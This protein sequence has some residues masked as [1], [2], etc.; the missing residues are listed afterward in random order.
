MSVDILKVFP[1]QSLN[2]KSELTKGP[3]VMSINISVILIIRLNVS[4]DFK[5]IM[6][7]ILHIADIYSGY[8]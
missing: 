5:S 7:T 8:N 1:L 2:A 4:A 6:D 3:T